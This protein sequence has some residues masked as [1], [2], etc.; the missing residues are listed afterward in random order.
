KPQN[1]K[2]PFKGRAVEIIIVLIVIIFRIMVK[3]LKKKE[4]YE[5]IKD[6]PSENSK[7]SGVH[8]DNIKAQ[9]DVQLGDEEEKIE[10]KK[11]GSGRLSVLEML[12]SNAYACIMDS[13]EC[14][15]CRE[16]ID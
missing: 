4:V 6:K 3:W 13:M 9:G 10:G 16:L 2:T 1:P 14:Q 7:F 12:D 8:K 11:D 15:I 5:P